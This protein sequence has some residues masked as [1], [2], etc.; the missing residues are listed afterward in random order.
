MVPPKKKQRPVADEI[1]VVEKAIPAEFFDASGISGDVAKLLKFSKFE[2]EQR[3][4]LKT[5]SKS[6]NRVLG[7]A[8]YGIPYGK[9]IELRGE[10]HGGKT[11]V[12]IILAGMAQRDGAG[13]GYIDLENSFDAEWN[14]RLGL[15]TTRIHLIEPKLVM[16]RKKKK[17]FGA[18]KEDGP[19]KQVIP[20]LQS[21]EEL[22]VEAETAMYL[23]SAAGAKKQ[24][25]IVDSI[26]NLAVET[27]LDAGTDG[28][29]MNTNNAR[30]RFLASTLPKWCGLAANYNATIFFINQLRDRTGLVFGSPTYSPGGRALR[31]NLQVRA[32]IRRVKH[33]RL[34]QGTHTIGL[35]GKIVNFKNKAGRGSVQ[36]EDCGFRVLWKK[37]PAQVEFMSMEKLEEFL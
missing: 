16:P 17:K 31:H 30:A 4:W 15:D 12:S 35:A 7:S 19:K 21:A 6:L 8:K 33:G 1:V 9:L 26:A 32:E 11:V 36:D 24:F 14:V 2:P 29:N 23:M 37:S 25:W 5:G 10:E 22:F 28:Q 13:V 18:K 20:R 34:K 3:Y 27:V